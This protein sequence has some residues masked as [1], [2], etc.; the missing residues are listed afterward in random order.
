[1]GGITNNTVCGSSESTADT[2]ADIGCEIVGSANRFSDALEKAKS[3]PFEIAI[4][5]VNLNGDNTLPIAEALVQRGVAFVFATGYDSTNLPPSLQK[6][7]VLEK[8]FQQG[9]WSEQFA[10]RFMAGP[11]VGEACSTRPVA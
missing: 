8:P 4:L 3:L 5:D 10:R 9:A 2:L 11:K 7:P 1:L 6:V